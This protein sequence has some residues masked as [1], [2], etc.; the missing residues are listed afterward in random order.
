MSMFRKPEVMVAFAFLSYS[1]QNLGI[2]YMK[3]ALD[4]LTYLFQNPFIIAINAKI[5]SEP[6]AGQFKS[7]F[8]PSGPSL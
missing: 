1:R 5:I 6:L 3:H 8:N 2:L 7:Y 4:S